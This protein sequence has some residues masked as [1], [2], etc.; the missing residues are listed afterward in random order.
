MQIKDFYLL[1]YVCHLFVLKT[2]KQLKAKAKY[3]SMKHA[4]LDSVICGCG[5]QDSTVFKSNWMFMWI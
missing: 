4:A 3:T 5:S 2:C 1:G